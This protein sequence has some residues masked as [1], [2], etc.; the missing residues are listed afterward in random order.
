MASKRITC[1]VEHEL[2][3]IQAIFWYYEHDSKWWL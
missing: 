1:T 2:T 3:I